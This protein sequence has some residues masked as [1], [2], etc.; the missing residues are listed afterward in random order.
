MSADLEMTSPNG[1]SRD[2]QLCFSDLREAGMPT[3]WSQPRFKRLKKSVD[4]RIFLCYTNHKR[5][6]QTFVVGF[7]H[8]IVIRWAQWLMIQER[9]KKNVYE[10]EEDR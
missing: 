8:A 10:E 4:I 3:E 1:K 6:Q 9:R 7:A 5:L 2:K